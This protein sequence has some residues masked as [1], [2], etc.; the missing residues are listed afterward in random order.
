MRC[1]VEDHVKPCILVVVDVPANIKLLGSDL[2]NE[3]TVVAATSGEECLKRVAQ[4]PVPELILLDVLMP[5]M[6]GFEVCRRLKKDERTEG[7]P[8]IFLAAVD[9]QT[10]EAEGLAVG[11]VDYISKPFS[12]PIIKNRI[13]IHLELREHRALLEQALVKSNRNLK[14]ARAEILRMV[15][16][17]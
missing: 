2:R 15:R 5:E 3:F 8:V 11:A 7:I 6:D 9:D 1:S 4:E 16:N 12:L 17:R 14:R 13:K 10:N